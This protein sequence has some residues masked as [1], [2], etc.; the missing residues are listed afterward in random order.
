MRLPLLLFLVLSVVRHVVSENRNRLAI[1]TLKIPE[2]LTTPK[3]PYHLP[4]PPSDV[5]P[6][7]FLD[8]GNNL[9]CDVCQNFVVVLHARLTN[10]EESSRPQLEQLLKHGCHLLEKVEILEQPCLNLEDHLLDSFF[11]IIKTYESYLTP[12]YV[13]G[14]LSLC[15]EKSPPKS[16]DEIC[17]SCLAAFGSIKNSL[18]PVANFLKTISEI[19][20]EKTCDRFLPHVETLEALCHVLDTNIGNHLYQFLLYIHK[21]MDEREICKF[22]RVC[23]K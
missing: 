14:S 19:A 23:S 10:L 4:S 18:P 6:I 20:I 9:I 12:S 3:T 1:P 5:A 15:A 17:L 2:G 7:P 21:S 8:P 16:D 13:C 11:K 22:I